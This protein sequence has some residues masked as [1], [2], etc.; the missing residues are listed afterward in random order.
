MR[1]KIF[2]GWLLVGAVLVALMLSGATVIVS[3]FGIV[4]AHLTDR[5]G[6]SQ[7]TMAGALSVALLATTLAV[8][9]VGLTVDRFGTRRTA[10]AGSLAFAAVL[11]SAGLMVRSLPG[12]YGFYALLGVVGAFTNPIVYIAALSAWF[13]RQRGVALGL[14]VAGQGLGGAVLP[15]GI[16]TIARQGGWAMAFAGMAVAVVLV[17]VPLILAFVHDHPAARGCLPDHGHSRPGGQAGPGGPAGAA[18]PHGLSLAEALRCRSF[19]I[20]MAVLALLGLTTYAYSGHLVAL[21]RAR[22]IATIGQAALLASVSGATMIL[23]RVAFGWLFD[24]FALPLVGAG[25]IALCALAQF[26]LLR[27][28]H[29]GPMV[30]VMGMLFGASMGAETDLLT[31]LVGRYFGTRALSRIYS[32]QNVAFLAGAAVGPVLFSALM[33][34]L[35]G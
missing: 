33:Q 1:F 19:W 2:P 10:I 30:L 29:F 13:D 6:W 31:L 21:M 16:E 12:F 32:W 15:V 17:A 25:G 24:R 5:F 14:A 18:A 34:G 7:V 20:I 27:L 26:L 23:S 3:S 11:A 4:T 28:D 22:H 35:G 8:P 9:L